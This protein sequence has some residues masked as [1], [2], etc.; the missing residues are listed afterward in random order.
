MVN[1]EPLTELDTILL[2]F[3]EG[4]IPIRIAV[5]NRIEYYYDFSQEIVGFKGIPPLTYYTVGT[6]SSAKLNTTDILY[7]ETKELMVAKIGIS[8]ASLRVF[9]EYPQ[10]VKVNIFSNN[11]WSASNP[12][13]GFVSGYDSSFFEPSKLEFAIVPHTHIGFDLYNNTQATVFPTFDI[14]LYAF[15][16]TYITDPKYIFDLITGQYPRKPIFYSLGS[17]QNPIVYANIK[18]YLIEGAP[19]MP[20]PYSITSEEDIHK[21]WG[22]Y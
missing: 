1:S 12:Q 4:F 11:V 17:Y 14:R 3:K 21:V 8:P 18:P 20:I 2:G 9:Y 22:G 10:G 16:Y 15:K 6:L 7:Y 5:M 19:P 13:F